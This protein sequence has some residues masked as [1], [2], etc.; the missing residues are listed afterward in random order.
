MNRLPSIKRFILGEK[1]RGAPT[2]SRI[3]DCKVNTLC[4]SSYTPIAHSHVVII[5]HVWLFMLL[6]VSFAIVSLAHVS[7]SSWFNYFIYLDT[8]LITQLYS[9]ELFLYW[10]PYTITYLNV[11]S[12]HSNTYQYLRLSLFAMTMKPQVIWI[13]NYLFFLYKYNYTQFYFCCQSL[14]SSFLVN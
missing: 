5:L 11:F 8:Q 10:N 3:L 12:L 2:L 7:L 9:L 1:R 13:H 4:H 14:I 6:L